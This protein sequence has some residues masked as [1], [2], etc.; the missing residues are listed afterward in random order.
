MADHFR[1]EIDWEDVRYF[2]ALAR[3]RSLS[4]TA[5]VL[6]V[7]HATVAR[8]LAGLERA[9]GTKLFERRPSG[10]ELTAAGRGALVAA[11]GMK[12]AADALP[13]LSPE[14]P[15]SGLVRVTATPSVV[16]RFLIPRLAILQQQHAGLDLELI[17]DIRPVSLPRHEA[18]IALRFGRPAGGELLGRRVA[19]VGFGFYATAAWRERIERGEPAAFIGFDEAGAH[20]PDAIWLEHRFP[21]GRLAFRTNSQTAQAEAARAGCGVALLPTFITAGDPVL[22]PVRLSEAPPSR[23]LWLL[24]RRDVAHSAPLRL[25]TDYLVDQF[26]RERR[27]FEGGARRTPS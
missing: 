3:H 11:G 13:R 22:V 4:A 7:N 24:T 27:L 8:R 6:A 14:R 21:K 10:Y 25:A 16:N 2:V 9:L 26:R 20:I 23:E 15:L 18:D 17:A 5:R 19:K 1:T 12:R